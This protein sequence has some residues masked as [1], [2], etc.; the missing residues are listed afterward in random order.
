MYTLERTTL[1]PSPREEVFEFF[2]NPKNLKRITPK[3]MDF[4]ITYI[5]ELPVRPGFRI[6][7]TIR[8]LIVKTRWVTLITDFER[9]SLFAD[10]QEKGPYKYWRHE[11][12][13]EAVDGDQTLMHDYVQYELPFGILGAVAHRLF[14]ARQ[15]KHI[16]DFRSRRIRKLF[17]KA[18]AQA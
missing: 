17:V 5:D 6:E 1:I 4:R 13:F 9:S 16:F 18:A 12:R 2:A 11:H 10:I 15:L 3:S 7:Y 14:V 8:P